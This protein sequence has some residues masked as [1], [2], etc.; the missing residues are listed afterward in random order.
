[1]S[2]IIVIEIRA[3][4]P[5]GRWAFIDRGEAQRQVLDLYEREAREGHTEISTSMV[6]REVEA[7]SLARRGMAS[8]ELL[9][10]ADGLTR[11]RRRAVLRASERLSEGR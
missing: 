5:G 7:A 8:G 2:K 11:L 3:A 9:S 1:M 4:G 10:V 6:I